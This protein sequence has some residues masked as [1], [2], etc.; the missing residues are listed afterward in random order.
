VNQQMMFTLALGVLAAVIAYVWLILHRWTESWR[1]F[2]SAFTRAANISRGDRKS[3]KPCAL[4]LNGKILGDGFSEQRLGLARPRVLVRPE[5]IVFS[6]S[7]DPVGWF[8][9]VLVRYD[10]IKSFGRVREH[11]LEWIEVEFS[12]LSVY[13]WAHLPTSL[14]RPLR[15]YGIQEGIPPYRP[16]LASPSPEDPHLSP[17]AKLYKR[18]LACSKWTAETLETLDNRDR[19]DAFNDVETLW[20]CVYEREH[21]KVWRRATGVLLDG[22]TSYWLSAHLREAMEKP[23]EVSLPTVTELLRITRSRLDR[24]LGTSSTSSFDPRSCPQCD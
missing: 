2:V 22:A 14:A 13:G 8:T 23:E 10:Q 4:V 1:P 9:P 15:G 18:T 3:A 7:P 16:G 6:L 20:G 19:L 12:G 5:G 24:A 21:A 11:S 17:A